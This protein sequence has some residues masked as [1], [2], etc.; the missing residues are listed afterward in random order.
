MKPDGTPPLRQ[1]LGELRPFL[2]VWAGQL[3]SALG[4]GLTAFAVAVVVYQRTGSAEAFGLLMFAWIFPALV[5]SPVA[6][7][8]VDRWDRRRLLIVADTGSGLL[9]L[10]TAALVLNGHFEV[11]YLFVTSALASAIASFQDPALTAAVAA[12]VPRSQYG[13]AIGL[14][15]VMQP[16]S[17]IVAPVIAGVLIATIGLGGIMAIDGATYL[18]AVG[19]LVWVAIP[20]PRQAPSTEDAAAGARAALRRFVAEAAVGWRFVRERPGLLGLLVCIALVNFW[21]SFVNPLLAPMVLSFTTPVQFAAVQASVGVGAVLGGIA[22]GAWG[23]PRNRIAGVLAAIVV[24]GVTM[25]GLGIRSIPVIAGLLFVWAA[26]SPLM[27]TSGMSIWMTKTP[28]ELMGR[29]AAVRRMVLMSMIPVAV[30]VAG[31]LAERVFEPLMMPG[32]ALAAS[33]GAL[34]GVGKG[35]GVALMFILLGVL[36]VL[37]A[38]G[39]WLVPSI[40]HVERDVPDAP[41]PHPD[42]EPVPEAPPVPELAAAD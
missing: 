5:L 35:R 27:L 31:P 4:S 36:V 32:A 11:W 39:G 28:Q 37:T 2:I 6:G 1:S 19:G 10:A 12:I 40:R 14:L 25:A 20:S 18:A 26:V 24:I 23:G 38:A 9:T 21:V 3:V 7:A 33:A 15:Q 22:M 29:V 34:I 41:H 13:R 17:M 42:G 8:L 30:L 16:V